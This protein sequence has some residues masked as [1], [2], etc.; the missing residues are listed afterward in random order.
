MRSHEARVASALQDAN[1][2]IDASSASQGAECDE[3]RHKAGEA[4]SLAKTLQEQ[5]LHCQGERDEMKS[6]EA[7]VASELQD[8]NHPTDASL[9][10]QVAECDKL[11]RKADEAE[12]LAKTL[13]EQ[14][15]HC[16][17][18]LDEARSHEAQVASEPRDANP[19][20][21]ASLVSQVAEF[22]ELRHKADEAQSMAKVLQGLEG[23][24]PWL[25]KVL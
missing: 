20:T 9:A 8:A 23:E 14:L 4:E 1:H 6:H 3:L 15:L 5:L 16:Q 21:D 11:R 18:E 10:S 7:R 24:A 19:P 17:G 2:S 25:E 13:Q 22:D 12:S